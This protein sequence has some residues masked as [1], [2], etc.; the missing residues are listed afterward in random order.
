MKFAIIDLGTNSI[1]LEIQELTPVG[2]WVSIYREKLM[3][4]LGE[5]LFVSK[6]LSKASKTRCV[7]VMQYFSEVIKFH[8]VDEID[9]FATS[10]LRDAIDAKSLIKLVKQ[11][12]GITLSVISGQEEAK[13]IAL[14]VLENE[15]LL[16]GHFAL[17]DIGGGSTEISICKGKKRLSSV[18]LDLGTARLNQL[19]LQKSPPTD[20]SIQKMKRF[21]RKELEKG[22]CNNLPKLTYV[23]GSSGTIR[24]ISRLISPKGSRFF[25]SVALKKLNKK[26]LKLELDELLKLKGME[27]RRV[28]MIVGGAILF[29]EIVEFLKVK[30]TKATPFSLRHGV[31]SRAYNKHSKRIM[32]ATDEEKLSEVL[33]RAPIQMAKESAWQGMAIGIDKIFKS[34]HAHGLSK[35]QLQ[36]L[37]W[38]VA[39]RKCGE[40]FFYGDAEF[41]SHYLAHTF[42]QGILDTESVELVTQLCLNYQGI[43]PEEIFYKKSDLVSKNQFIK[44]LSILRVIEAIDLRGAPSLDQLIR[45][46]RSTKNKFELRIKKT[47]LFEIQ[48]LRIEQRQPLFFESFG[49]QVVL[50]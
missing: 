18:S 34:I 3:I 44:L 7:S 47:Y 23:I 40:S 29:E 15:V 42:L 14:G 41:H 11:K 27:A 32:R 17:V 35:K 28:D 48:K 24:A 36:C 38:A 37:V 9:A 43:K 30:K 19:F 8:K 10:A 4:R 16:K 33:R 13:L 26:M 49:K 31:L 39:L 20:K 25:S 46:V 1:R 21:V 12:S 5:G 6:K 2:E 22:L 45:R 50:I